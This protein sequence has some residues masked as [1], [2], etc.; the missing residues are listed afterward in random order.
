MSFPGAML[1]N[2]LAWG[3][4]V[5]LWASLAVIWMLREVLGDWLLDCLAPGRGCSLNALQQWLHFHRHVQ[6]AQRFPSNPLSPQRGA[7]AQVH[8]EGRP[9]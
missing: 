4:T 9:S 8:R 1:L 2:R 7:C 3:Q 5:V 6:L